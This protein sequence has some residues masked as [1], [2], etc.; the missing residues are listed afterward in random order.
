MSVRATGRSHDELRP[1][2]IEIGI[3]RYAEGSCLVRAG[4]TQVLCLA[5]VESRVP[6]F[7]YGRGEGWVTAEYAMLPRATAERT[8]RERAGS[9]PAGRTYE[10]QRM[11]GRALRAVVDR[12]QIGERTITVDCDVLQADGGTRCASI[13]GGFVA[14]ALAIDGLGGERGF[15]GRPLLDTVAAVSCGIVAGEALLD[16]AYEE[17]SAAEVDFNVVRTGGKRYVELQGTAEQSPF[18]RRRLDELLDLADRGLDRL[19]EI[20]REALGD[21]LAR[22]LGGAGR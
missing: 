4:Q 8:S 12:K 16:L 5:T 7:L 18:A 15:R 6:S 1:F 17:D 11:I 20:Q 19:D 2:S 14:L 9:R 10:I 21:R 22:L 3:N 13:T